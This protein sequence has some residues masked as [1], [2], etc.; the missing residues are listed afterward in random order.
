MWS[1]LCKSYERGRIEVASAT[2]SLII[3]FSYTNCIARSHVSHVLTGRHTVQPTVGPREGWTPTQSCS[4]ATR[5]SSPC[6]S[7]APMRNLIAFSYIE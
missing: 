1:T 2:T 3:S 5:P 6:W 4:I 7:L